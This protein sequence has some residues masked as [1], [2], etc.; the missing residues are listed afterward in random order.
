MPNKYVQDL[1]NVI[2]DIAGVLFKVTTEADMIERFGMQGQIDF[3]NNLIVLDPDM[4]DRDTLSVLV[5]EI[6][7]GIVRRYQIQIQH[8]TIVFLECSLF[9]V[10]MSNPILLRILLKEAEV[11]EPL[12]V[13]EDTVEQLLGE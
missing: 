9:T 4:G 11:G 1:E 7:E 5:H 2:V 10:L 8:E 13:E 12:R 3:R 6:I